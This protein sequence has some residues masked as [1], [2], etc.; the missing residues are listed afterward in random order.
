[1]TTSDTEVVI[2]A[3]EEW[4]IACQEKFN[5]MWAFALWDN[6]N[7]NYFFRGTG[8]ARSHCIMPFMITALFSDLK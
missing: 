5:G 8:L 6:R 7:S 4:G 3:Y 2:R 1:M